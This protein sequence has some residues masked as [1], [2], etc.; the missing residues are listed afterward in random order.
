MS[1]S[2]VRSESLVYIEYQT[3]DIPVCS[4]PTTVRHQSEN[5]PGFKMP[6][7][8][9]SYS[10]SAKVRLC[11]DNN[12]AN[13]CLHFLGGIFLFDPEAMDLLHVQIQ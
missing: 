1:R 10:S 12:E 8:S 4:F 11:F 9:Y 5:Y 7:S 13:Q 3:E 6:S 2:F